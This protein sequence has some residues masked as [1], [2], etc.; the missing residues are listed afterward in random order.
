MGAEVYGDAA[1]SHTE[2]DSSPIAS[3][4]STNMSW[5]IPADA[6]SQLPPRPALTTQQS[7][8]VPATP[9]HHPR[10]LRFPSRSHSRSPSPNRRSSSPRSAH[11]ELNHILP[12]RKQYGGCKYETAMAH[13]R[14]RMPYSLG[15]DLLPEEQGPLKDKLA[16]E[17]EERLTSHMKELYKKLLPSAESEQRRIKFVKKLENLLNTQWPGNDIKVHVFGSS[18]NKLCSSD[19]D[20]DICITTPFKELEHVCLLADFL[21]K[22]G[23]ERVVCVSHAKVPIVKIWDPELQVACDMNVNNTMALE[24]T[25]M[26]R[27]YVEVDERVRPLAMIVKHWTKQRILND[28]ALGGTLSSYTW[29]CLIINFLQTRSP[30]IVPSLQ[31]RAISRRKQQGNGQSSSSFDDN[32]EELASFGHKNK[33]TLGELLFQF[34]RYYGHE[35]DYE[36][37]VMSV[38]EGKLVSKEGKGWHLLQNNRL[39]VEE[40]FNTSRNLGN[41]ADDTSFRGLHLE[42]RRAFEAVAIGDLGKCCERYEYPPEEERTWERPAP[43]PRAILTPMPALPSRGGR[44][45]GRGG[46]HTNHYHRGPNNMGRRASNTANRNNIRSA[47]PSFTADIAFQAQQAQSILHDHL[48]QRIQILQAQ[49]QELRM[50]L[51]NQALMTGRAPPTLLRQPYLQFTLPQHENISPEENPRVRASSVNQPPLTAPIR[52]NVFFN[53]SYVPVTLPGVQGTNTNPPSPSL[54]S[55]VPDVRR[56]HRRSSVAN[57]SPRGLRAQ[58]QPARPVP[59]VMLPNFPAVQQ[60]MNSRRSPECPPR[61]VTEGE[62]YLPN[63]V[64]IPKPTFGD[65]NLPSEYVGYYVG[66]STQPHGSYRGHLASS[67]PGLAI[68]GCEVPAYLHSS[69]EYRTYV[70]MADQSNGSSGHLSPPK[71][72]SHFMQPQRLTRS[73]TLP[74]RGPL[75]ID[76]SVPPSEHRHSIANHSSE[77]FMTDFS[78]SS[79]ADRMYDTPR[80]TPD[81]LS[82]GLH[83]QES[84]DD[85]F[86]SSFETHHGSQG[87]GHMSG[88]EP[89]LNH[90]D[91]TATGHMG[92]V[93]T[94]SE[95]LQRFQLS[96]PN[97]SLDT[98][99][100]TDANHY[101]STQ[102]LYPIDDQLNCLHTKGSP[103]DNHP[104][105]FNSAQSPAKDSRMMSPTTK[106]CVNGFDFEKVNGMPHK[107]KAK[108]RYE[109]SNSFPVSDHKEKQGDHYRKSNGGH[110]LHSNANGHHSTSN[111]WQTTKRRNKKGPKLS[112]EQNDGTARPEPIPIDESER[113]GG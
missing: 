99:R 69:P 110:H 57:D 107:P 90:T 48:Y 27:T 8:S 38:R 34:F 86:G 45:G 73:Q 60:D 29:I 83:E 43:Q 7:S 100:N 93:E 24:N 17:D 5:P 66:D 97:F 15:A 85:L 44:G 46:R 72:G 2:G 6:H 82:Q 105:L 12:L 13:F 9:F 59:S 39:C 56:S 18:G 67:L 22:N 1:S 20:V 11:S 25:R 42:L 68:H 21:A 95:R 113:K 63:G 41:T 78:T 35:V 74:D 87:A 3:E 26:I 16:P 77:Q 40:P 108:G 61:S 10:G 19:S 91:V 94:L 101:R 31:K 88:W 50:Q 109:N 81:T 92:R 37:N 102:Y 54:P 47:N 4:T 64:A 98:S 75:I 49:E 62:S 84:Y 89:G 106:H 80:T 23:M 14:R 51:Q 65:E 30:P 71:I 36:K 53:T 52:Q 103:E 58:S 112:A 33:S 32:L 76:G 70:T 28:A 111:G 79:S 55:A 96:D 104:Q